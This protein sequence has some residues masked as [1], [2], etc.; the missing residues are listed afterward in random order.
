MLPGPL[1]VGFRHA[2]SATPTC[3]PARVALTA[4]QS[5]E[6]HGRVGYT[7]GIP[8]D[9]T[10]PVSL[11]RELGQVGYQCQAIGKM[12]VWPERSR[13]GFDEVLLQISSVAA[14]REVQVAVAGSAARGASWHCGP[15]W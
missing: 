14:P 12:H 6:A 9:R 3:V 4:G 2:Y 8:F 5:Q 11:P 15:V 7:D 1:Q 13:I 10:H